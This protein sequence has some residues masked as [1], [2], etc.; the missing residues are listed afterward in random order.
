[1]DKIKARSSKKM[2]SGGVSTLSDGFRVSMYGVELELDGTKAELHEL[3]DE[4]RTMQDQLHALRKP[5]TAGGILDWEWVSSES[6]E[7]RANNIRDNPDLANAITA[8]PQE[9]LESTSR[10][11]S[12]LKRCGTVYAGSWELRM[13]QCQIS[14]SSKQGKSSK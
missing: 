9:N 12:M 3:K 6:V 4:I 2:R 10:H 11:R 5:L 8:V 1:M 7:S 14:S 13:D